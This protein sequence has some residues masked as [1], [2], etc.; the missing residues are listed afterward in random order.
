MRTPPRPRLDEG[1][2]G[3]VYNVGRGEGVTVK[4]VLEPSAR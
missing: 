1:D 2:L 4:E 3:E